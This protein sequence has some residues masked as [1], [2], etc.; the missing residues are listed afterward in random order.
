MTDRVCI[1]SNGTKQVHLSAQDVTSCDILGDMGCNGGIP[2]TVYT[3]W[4]LFGIVP[5][6]NYGDK[7]M[8]Y[9]YQLKPCA[10]HSVSPKYPNCSGSTK[11]PKC[12]R[13][14]IDKSMCYSYQLKPCA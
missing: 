10:H 9:S 5:G 12:M 3:Y 2:S 1:A 8:C 6:G 4:K 14:C 11:T 13:Q 7:S